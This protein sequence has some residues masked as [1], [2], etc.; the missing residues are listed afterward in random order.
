M[1]KWVI[2]VR[3]HTNRKDLTIQ[4]YDAETPT[5]TYRRAKEHA[6]RIAEK[7]KGKGVT[8]DVISR[9]LA[10]KKPD[11]VVVGKGHLWCPYCIKPR[12]F[13]LDEKLNIERCPVC[14]VSKHEFYVQ[15]YN[16]RKK[17]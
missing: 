17:V 6:R 4:S 9:T 2:S 5:D 14:G 15:R 16:G 1:S 8:V 7:Y 10:F 3:T 12:V 13:V 11:K